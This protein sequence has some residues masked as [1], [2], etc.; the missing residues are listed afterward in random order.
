MAVNSMTSMAQVYLQSNNYELLFDEDGEVLIGDSNKTPVDDGDVTSCNR[1]SFVG[2]F[3]PN[4]DY[5][6]VFVNGSVV[7]NKSEGLL[8]FSSDVQGQSVVLEYIS[9]G[10]YNGVEGQ[11]DTLIKIHKF[12]ENALV[13]YIHYSLIKNRR[14]VPYNEKQRARKEYYNSHRISKRRISSL[15]KDDLLQTF[16][17]A[18]RWIKS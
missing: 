1:F 6:K 8:Q 5:S 7:L 17:G 14:N 2:G 13:D 16:K 12:A 15:R 10:L 9:D 4:K 18:N 3:T 11:D